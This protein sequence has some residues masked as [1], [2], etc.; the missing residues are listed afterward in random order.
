MYPELATT[1]K[2]QIYKWNNDDLK[3]IQF[4]KMKPLF[5]V[6]TNLIAFTLIIFMYEIM[7]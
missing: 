5:G 6:Y 2:N 4:S 3:P 7:K 1:I